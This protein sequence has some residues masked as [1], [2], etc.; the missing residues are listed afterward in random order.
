M[1]IFTNTQ[2]GLLGISIVVASGD[3]GC[4][5]RT[6]EECFLKQ[7]KKMYP[8]YPACSPFVTSVGGTALLNPRSDVRVVCVLC[9]LHIR[10]SMK[11]LSY[12]LNLY[13]PGSLNA[14]FLR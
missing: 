10:I 2:I 1:Y 3:S 13:A 12:E 6:D 5:G 7:G 9:S 14:L 11:Y 4:H 8:D